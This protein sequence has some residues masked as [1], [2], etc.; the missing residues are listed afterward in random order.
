VKKEY[1]DPI[2][3]SRPVVIR[4]NPE[5]VIDLLT[6]I[7]YLKKLILKIKMI[8]Q[9]EAV[10]S[11][12][13]ALEKQ[14]AEPGVISDLQ[15][16][17]DLLRKHK[18]LKIAADL[19][20]HY[21]SI[22]R[23]L[24]EYQ[25]IIKSNDDPELTEMAQEELPR[26]EAEKT[27]LEEELKIALLPKDENASRNIIA[28]IRAGT[29]GEEAALFAANLFRMYE[30]YC[31][32]K[33]WKIDIMNTHVAAAGGLKEIIVSITG[34]EVYGRMKFESGVH[35][36]QR[37]PATEA[38]GRIHTSA[39]SVAILPEVEDIEIEINPNELKIDVFRSSGPG[40]QSVNT[41]D[42]AVRVTHLPTSL[43][44]SCQ[45]EK[46][47]LKNKAKAIKVLKARLYQQQLEEEQAK[48]AA[49]RRLQVGTG[50]RS[51][52]IRTYNFP[53]SRVTDHRIGL[54]LY[55]LNEILDGDMDELTDALIT[56][57]QNRQLE[58]LAGQ[59]W[60]DD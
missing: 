45:D 24:N 14:L 8:E 13:D 16:Y 21:L 9:V 17:R 19:S 41:T 54:T 50:D 47:Q 59:T 46:S 42:S 38:S 51:A 32:R 22:L 48:L 34:E 49:E 35:R 37:V 52:K 26:L 6:I 28:E 36:V 12:F 20:N 60:T 33:N 23:D 55:R 27:R 56:A 1:L 31:E 11:N 44:V 30:R 15:R 58:S 4:L 40:G 39:A 5:N 2:M 57:N 25:A 53:Q 18:S 43:V 10:L 29:G 3:R 7:D